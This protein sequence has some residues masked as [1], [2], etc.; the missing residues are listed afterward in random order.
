[1]NKAIF[2]ILSAVLPALA[3]AEVTL[4]GNIRSGVSVSQT[5]IGGERHTRSSVD[6]LGSYIGLRGSHPI[7]G[8]NKAV[9]QYQQDVPAGRGGGSMREYFR[10]KKN[11]GAWRSGG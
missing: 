10:E 1:M 2:L 8:G 7:G 11:G 3:A 6:D 4:Y 5:K 9:W